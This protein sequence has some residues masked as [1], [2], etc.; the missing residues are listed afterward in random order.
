MELSVERSETTLGAIEQASE[1][2]EQADATSG[3]ELC[4]C[5][6]SVLVAARKEIED[7]Q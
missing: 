1:P 4:L 6:E 7:R 3:G 2:S 5:R